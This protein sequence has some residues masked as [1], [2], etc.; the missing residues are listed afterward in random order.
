MGEAALVVAALLLVITAVRGSLAA[1]AIVAPARAASP[2]D[3]ADVTVLVAVRSGD[4]LLPDVLASSVRTLAP[5]R[6]LL[7][8]DDDD[9][10]GRA[11][12][13][14]AARATGATA[15]VLVDA[16]AATAATWRP[17]AREVA[18]EVGAV[19]GE[20]TRRPHVEVVVCPPPGPGVNP[21]VHKLALADV[22]SRTVV[23][24]DDD[25]ALPA[26][27]LARLV[28]ALGAADLATGVPVYREQGG[29]WSRLLAAFVNGSALVTY[30]P[31][32]QVGP[33]VSVNGMVVALRRDRLEGVGGFAALATATCDDYALARLF[34]AHG[35][36]IVQTS[37]PAIVATTVPTAAAYL[38]TV[39]RWLLFAG[40]V[41]RR[42]LSA[43]LLLL[44][45][46][47][48]ALPLVAVVLAVAS[49]SLAA[50]GA[51]VAALAVP[52]LV[53]RALRLRV[54]AAVPPDAASADHMASPIHT[55]SPGWLGVLLE[56][57]A[58]VLAPLQAVAAQLG[59]RTVTWRGRRVRVGIGTAP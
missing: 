20:G 5:A 33:P 14:A 16:A 32:A 1:V 27:G 29:L 43:R 50:V 51:G 25:T 4:P 46:V 24:L 9:T 41:V 31:L 34:R 59:P 36:R 21:K 49:G 48:T 19:R 12:A 8:V 53:T 55:T 15:A 7:L 45:L 40:E 42:D 13:T 6:V 30:L 2:Q 56:P 10:A 52:A 58:A 3:L 35:L 28:G 26:G 54:M 44:V 57:V 39:R 22:R 47:P 11:A 17:A 38:R 37:Q 23:L 18:D